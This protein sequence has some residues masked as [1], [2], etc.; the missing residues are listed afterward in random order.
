MD[1]RPYE[2]R[3]RSSCIEV[4]N[5]LTPEL[6]NSSAL[7][8][9][10]AWLDRPAGPYFVMAHE[11]SVVGCGGYAL[12]EDRSTAALCW[13][14]VR[15]SSQ[16]MGLGRF[17]LMYRIREVGKEG[18]VGVL[19]AHSPRP[20]VGFFQKQGFRVTRTELEAHGPGTELIELMKKLTVCP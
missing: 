13:G 14:M 5:S 17:L 15:R 8:F 9:F 4:F 1:V 3:D 6:L 2:P 20:S 19:F 10:E 18:S 7:S 12:S 16:K 11:E